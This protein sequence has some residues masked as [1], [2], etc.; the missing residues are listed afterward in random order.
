MWRELIDSVE[1]QGVFSRPASEDLIGQAERQLG[2]VFP[3]EL[4]RLLG[5]T[6]GIEGQYGLGIIWPVERIVADNIRFRTAEGEGYMPFESL[7][8]FADAGNGDQFAFPVTAAGQARDEVFAWDHEDHSRRW[9]A[10]SLRG[11]LTG[12]LR[13][14]LEL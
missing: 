11:Y 5:E 13:G 10:D 8:F 9:F 6:D 12:W 7:L 2:M 1:R 4:R 14:E 3:D